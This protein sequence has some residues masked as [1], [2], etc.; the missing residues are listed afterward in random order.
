M[1]SPSSTS[2]GRSYIVTIGIDDYQNCGK[3][4]NAVGDATGALKA[5]TALG[6]ESRRHLTNEE[7]TAAAMA[8]LVR[9]DL[10]SLDKED[11]L[12]VFFAGHGYTH[13]QEFADTSCIKTG[14]LVPVDGDAKRPGTCVRIRT[15]LDEITH[16]PAKHI[17]VILDACKSGV[18]LE[19]MMHW[20]PSVAHP[21]VSTPMDRLRQR[22]S[23]RVFTSALDD[24]FASDRGP[25]KGNS[26]FTGYL[27][28]ALGGAAGFGMTREGT[29]A[30]VVSSYVRDRV[31]S[32]PRS[33]QTPDFGALQLDD[34]G[35]LVMAL[36]SRSASVETVAAGVPTSDVHTRGARRGRK[37]AASAVALEPAPAPKK[38]AGKRG[39]RKKA[40]LSDTRSVELSVELD[41]EELR[42]AALS[43]EHDAHDEDGDDD[44]DDDDDDDGDEP[45][46][47]SAVAPLRSPILPR[48]LPLRQ[49]AGLLDA[50]LVAA[51]DRHAS[52]RKQG[53][54]MLTTLGS[55]ASA[56]ASDEALAAL[57]TYHAQRGALTLVISAPSID[58]A[59]DELLAQMPWPRCL[60][61]ARTE[62]C[63]AAKIEPASLEAHLEARGERELQ[64]WIDDMAAG[65]P[66]VRVAGWLVAQTRYP[67]EPYDVS[68]APLQGRELIGAL[69]DLLCPIAIALHHEAPTA[70]WL[71]EAVGVAAAL[72]SRLPWHSISLVA[73]AALLGEVLE[74]GRDS[75]AKTMARQGRVHA[76]AALGPGG[77]GGPALSDVLD[78]RGLEDRLFAALQSD[79]RARNCFERR[80]LAPIHERERQ[81]EVMLAARSECLLVE[82]DRWYHVREADEYRRARLKDIWLQ[83][84]GFLSLR[85]PAEDIA[86]RLSAVVD[87]ICAGLAGRRDEA[88]FI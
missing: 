5:F 78:E 66:A 45:G 48:E 58:A 84:A 15:W 4:K 88:L 75:M 12:V 79:P 43:E 52:H 61:A 80:V 38:P 54:P 64:R 23:R 16:L 20:H 7:A 67:G 10:Q 18:A 59:V 39:R 41:D 19:P 70:A 6:F 44:D 36:P 77:L 40:E 32:F 35:E 30:S 24:E 27:I 13:K 3:L 62:I 47:V 28:E 8:Q 83:R 22:R 26:L 81:V 9:D 56:E 1:E 49:G 86:H 55:S 69:G 2:K 31:I 65:R 25:F 14:Y 82:I 74:G 50:K 76:R 73:P 68:S 87:E 11:S 57:A 63:R 29:P 53:T 21:S 72:C 85:F 51:L 34:R 17:L 71:Q 60:A 37:S 46:L 33:R 42:L